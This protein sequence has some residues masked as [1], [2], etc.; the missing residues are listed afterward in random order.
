MPILP[1]V[2]RDSN[3]VNRGHCPEHG[4]HGGLICTRCVT[5]LPPRT[6]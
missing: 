6:T 2:A 1:T 5:S 4:P 3:P